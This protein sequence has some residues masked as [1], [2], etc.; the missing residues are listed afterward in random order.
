[1]PNRTSEYFKSR[2][3][4]E[5]LMCDFATDDREAE[6]HREMADRYLELA[7]EFDVYSLG[8]RRQLDPSNDDLS[9]YVGTA[10]KGRKQTEAAT[11]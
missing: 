10:V 11:S 3:V 7:A 9:N 5:R 4:A 1:M 2:A 6:A 8:A